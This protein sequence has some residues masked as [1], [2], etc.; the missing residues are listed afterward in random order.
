[1]SAACRREVHAAFATYALRVTRTASKSFVC[2]AIAFNLKEIIGP[3]FSAFIHR[4]F[5]RRKSWSAPTPPKSLF[6]SPNCI[7]ADARDSALL[8]RARGLSVNDPSG[9]VYAGGLA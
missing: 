6:N 1:M 9:I 5:V 2:R 7:P 8:C 4:P 3:R